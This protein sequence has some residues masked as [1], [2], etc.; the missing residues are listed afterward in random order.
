MESNYKT[1]REIN[2]EWSTDSGDYDSIIQ[3]ELNSYRVAAW[4]KQILSQVNSDHPLKILDI[5]CGPAFFSIILARKGHILTAIDGAAGMLEKARKN[6]EREALKIELL[7]MDCHFLNFADE[8]FDLIVSRNVTHT[9]ID[10]VQAYREWLRVLKKEGTLLIF[11]AN[12]HLTCCPGALRD[13]YLKDVQ[14]CIDL[15]GCDFNGNTRIDESYELMTQHRLKDLHRPDWDMGIL[16][17][18]GYRNIRCE[19]DITEKLWDEKE[20]TIYRTTPMF[21]ICGQK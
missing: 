17:A 13:Q 2:N 15:F 8:A 21:M 1:Q 16:N 7:E 11:D 6:I 14:K 3:D 5:G 9:L 12:W 10:H 4:Q 19:R 18:L 20:K